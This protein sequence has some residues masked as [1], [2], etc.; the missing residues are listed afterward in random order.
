MKHGRLFGSLAVLAAVA[1]SS[2]GCVSAKKHRELQAQ[3]SQLTA[4]NNTLTE[5]KKALTQQLSQAQ[6]VRTGL[7][8]ELKATSAE[9]GSARAEIE[10]L[11][12]AQPTAAG[13]GVEGETAVFRTTVGSDILFA[14]GEATLTNEGKRALDAVVAKLKSRYGGMTVRVYGHTDSDRIA[15]TKTLWQDNL[16]LSANR[17]MAVT[18]YLRSKGIS[19]SQ[20]ETVAM[21]KTRPV[22]SNSTRAGKAKNRRVEIVVVK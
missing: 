4:Q 11:K 16:D 5:Q 22:A 14:A 6:S 8:S 20:I 10:R 15:R 13:G 18:R 3:Y 12:S 7:D 9:L 1:V 21:G 19:A 2:V 17:A